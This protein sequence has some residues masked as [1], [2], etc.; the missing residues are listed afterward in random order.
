M[1]MFICRVC[2][3]YANS[4]DGCEPYPHSYD[5]VCA[6][7]ID[8]GRQQTEEVQAIC[9]HEKWVLEGEA[10]ECVFCGVLDMDGSKQG[11]SRLSRREG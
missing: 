4:D 3:N 1:G 8:N 9:P 10:P 5:L 11:L 2:G 6:D 7:C